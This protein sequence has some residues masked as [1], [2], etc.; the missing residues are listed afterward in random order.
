VTHVGR[1]LE[2]GELEL[3]L[4]DAGEVVGDGHVTPELVLG[5][6]AQPVD[7]LSVTR[8]SLSRA[9]KGQRSTTYSSL[10]TG[11]SV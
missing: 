5:L 7:H 4:L 9:V 2:P 3:L 8:A 10:M 6:R 1:R 11:G